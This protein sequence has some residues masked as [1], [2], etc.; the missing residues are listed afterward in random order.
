MLNKNKVAKYMAGQHD[1]TLNEI[2]YDLGLTE[3]EDIQTLSAIL[4]ELEEEG[5]IIKSFCRQH[6]IE[7]YDSLE[8]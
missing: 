1:L 6:K 8:K 3:T 5:L 2:T 7:E 4:G